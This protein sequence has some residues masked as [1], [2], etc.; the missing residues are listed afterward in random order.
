[1]IPEQKPMSLEHLVETEDLGLEILHPGGLEITRELAN[2]CGI[3]SGTSVLDVAAGTGETAC[4]LAEQR[5]ARVVGIDASDRMLARAKAKAARRALKIELER[6][7]AHSLPF[8]SDTFDV[9]ISECSVCL[10]DKKRAL[11]E[12]IRVTKPGGRLGIDDVCWKEGAP[13]ELKERLA[14]LEGER[15]ESIEGWQRL[16]ENAGLVDARAIDRSDLIQ[17][18]MREIRNELGPAGELKLFVNVLRRWG[19][20]G[21]KR[22]FE[23]ERIFASRYLGYCITVG[24]KPGPGLWAAR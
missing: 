12:M 8:P 17:A 15:P 24:R 23:S 3:V 19:F 21:L 5:G 4:Y 22:V 11:E 10:F 20:P 16:F 13:E 2:L 1:M 6:G 9:V 18:W 14:E 7:D